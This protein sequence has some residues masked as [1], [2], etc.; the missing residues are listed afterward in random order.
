M[1]KKVKSDK[2]CP[3]CGTVLKHGDE[4]VFCDVSKE[5]LTAK[6]PLEITVFWKDTSTNASRVECCSW[7]CVKEFLYNFPWNKKRVQF[8][9]LPYIADYTTGNFSGELK[10]YFNSFQERA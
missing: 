5:R 6:Y 1:R 10:A 9:N 3:T 2:I 4:D 8:I 7:K